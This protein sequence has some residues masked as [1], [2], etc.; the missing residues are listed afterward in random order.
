MEMVMVL[1]NLMLMVISRL[2]A[3]VKQIS[4]RKLSNHGLHQQTPGMLNQ[5]GTKI[6]TL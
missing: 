2:I 6:L 1:K 4:I 5:D 3:P